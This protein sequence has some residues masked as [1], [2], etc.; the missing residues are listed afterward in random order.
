MARNSVLEQAIEQ[1][2]SNPHSPDVVAPG[3][4]ALTP[5]ASS[6]EQSLRNEAANSSTPPRTQKEGSRCQDLTH[7]PYPAVTFTMVTKDTASGA[8]R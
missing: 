4:A 5:T 3:P 7:P 2:I 1:V 6:S 8:H